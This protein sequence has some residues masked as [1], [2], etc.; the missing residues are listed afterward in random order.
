MTNSN[1]KPWR[2]GVSGNPKGRPKGSR[3]WSKVVNGLLNDEQLLEQLNKASLIENSNIQGCKNALEL[4]SVAQITR[5]INGD[6]KAAE[7]LRKIQDDYE[8]THSPDDDIPIAL[9]RFIESASTDELRVIAK[10]GQIDESK[11]Q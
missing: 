2:P 7:W 4:I 11:L 8:L 9:V 3:S 1:L 10:T 5:A 6:Y